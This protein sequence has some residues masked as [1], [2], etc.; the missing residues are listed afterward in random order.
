MN[1]LDIT[2]VVDLAHVVEDSVL[3]HPL[4]FPLTFGT[5]EENSPVEVRL[6]TDGHVTGTLVAVEFLDDVGHGFSPWLH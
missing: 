5:N 2:F 1:L 6:K 4:V 3:H